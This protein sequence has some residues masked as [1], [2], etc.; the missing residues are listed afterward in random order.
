MFSVIGEINDRYKLVRLQ[1]RLEVP[2]VW[3]TDQYSIS[4]ERGKRFMGEAVISIYVD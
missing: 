2:V 4:V 1:S 3:I